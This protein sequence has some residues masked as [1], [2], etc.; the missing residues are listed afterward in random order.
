MAEIAD[1]LLFSY[2]TL[3]LPAVQLDTFGRIVPTES[4]TLPGYRIT[5]A[6]KLDGRTLDLLGVPRYPMVRPTDSRLDRVPG[7]VLLLTEDELEAADEYVAA[8]EFVAVRYWRATRLLGSGRSAWVF[9][10]G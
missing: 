4:D 9:V 6:E 8:E 3:R 2:G 7:A 1:Q 5:Y 10:S